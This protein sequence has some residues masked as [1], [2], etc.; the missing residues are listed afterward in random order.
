MAVT[1]LMALC[2]HLVLV[3]HKSQLWSLL[4]QSISSS[5]GLRVTC[6]REQCRH[7]RGPGHIRH[8]PHRNA[9]PPVGSSSDLSQRHGVL[10]PVSRYTLRVLFARA[11]SSRLMSAAQAGHQLTSNMLWHNVLKVQNSHR[12]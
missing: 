10:Q 6:R 5:S 3:C 1:F 9:A 7:W 2:L 12:S 8:R 4:Q 11:V